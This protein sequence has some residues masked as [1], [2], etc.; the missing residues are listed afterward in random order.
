MTEPEAAR[1][2]LNYAGCSAPQEQGGW[3]YK[4]QSFDGKQCYKFTEPEP[5]TEPGGGKLKSKCPKGKECTALYHT[6]QTG[7][8]WL[9]SFSDTDKETAKDITIYLK[10]GNEPNRIQKIFKGA[11][12]S[13][14]ANSKTDK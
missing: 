8:G 9:K 3:I 7:P 1:R 10:A 4:A 13:W 11:E 12:Q 2:G 6:H 5:T 14:N